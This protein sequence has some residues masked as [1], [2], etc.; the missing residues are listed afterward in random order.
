MMRNEFQ[1]IRIVDRN[2][3]M[4]TVNFL[5]TDITMS[6]SNDLLREKIKSNIYRVINTIPKD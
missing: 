4:S 2:Q 1:E 3:N 5:N 6:I